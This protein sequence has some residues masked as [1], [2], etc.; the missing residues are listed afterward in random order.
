[1]PIWLDCEARAS[2]I[3][4]FL[5]EGLLRGES[6][7]LRT[8]S[9]EIRDTL[10][11]AELIK[12]RGREVGL[13]LL[14]DITDRKRAEI[15]LQKSEERFRC[16]VE[17][18]R[19]II[20]TIDV[21]GVLTYVNPTAETLMG[22]SIYELKG[23]SFEQIVAPECIDLVKDR[24]KRAMKGEFIPVYEIDMIRK[25]GARLPIEFNGVNYLRQ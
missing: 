14:Y 21:N 17:T 16:M 4:K 2:F 19:D 20:Y 24:F 3:R 18:T 10:W 5:K 7:Q 9:G 23:K 8:K 15:A 1:M 13:L 12:Y 6:V 22:Y 25:D 11:S